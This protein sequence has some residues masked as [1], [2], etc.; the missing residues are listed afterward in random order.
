MRVVV[1]TGTG[2]SFS[3]APTS[4]GRSL[5]RRGQIPPVSIGKNLFLSLLELSK[6]LVGAINGVATG[7]GSG[8]RCAA[9]SASGPTTP[10]SPPASAASV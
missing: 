8:S 1:L 6:P 7:S 4:A 3:R 10:G 5:G 2:D 9:T